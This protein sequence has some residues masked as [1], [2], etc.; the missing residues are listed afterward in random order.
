MAGSSC[1]PSAD[2]LAFRSNAGVVGVCTTSG[3]LKPF[4]FKG[5]TWHGAETT[6]MVPGGLD[7]HE[8]SFYFSFLLRNGFN[9][10]QL[11]FNH[12]SV[13]D[14]QPIPTD[15]ISHELNGALFAEYDVPNAKQT[16]V[17]YVEMLKQ[18][19]EAAQKQGMLVLLTAGRLTP[20]SWPGDGLW[21]NREIPEATL[22]ET[23]TTLAKAL[24]GSWNLLGVDLHHEP[25]KASWAQGLASHRWDEAAE[26][27]GNHILSECPRWLV[28]VEGI[29][30][31]APEDGGASKGYWWGENLVGALTKPITLTDPTRLVY[32]P[33]VEGPSSYLQS[34][35][36][37]R[38]FP[39]NLEDIWMDHF[40]RVKAKT[41]TPFVVGKL[42][43]KLDADPRDLMWLREA[44]AYFPTQS[45]GVFYASLGTTAEADGLL[46]DDWTTPATQ[47]LELLS[48][49]P[50]TDVGELRASSVPFPPPPVPPPHPP[51]PPPP[52]RGWPSPPPAP[53]PPPPKFPPGTIRHLTRPPPSPPP[54]SPPPP[55]PSPLPPRPPPSPLRPPPGL[56]P[57]LPLVERVAVASSAAVVAAGV[58]MS[59]GLIGVALGCLRI[60]SSGRS[61][62]KRRASSRGRT[63][64]E[65]RERGAS[66]RQQ[67]VLEARVTTLAEE[68][69][70]AFADIR[71]EEKSAAKHGVRG[72]MLQ[73]LRPWLGDKMLAKGII[74]YMHHE[75]R[76]EVATRATSLD[77]VIDADAI[78]I[79][80]PV[81]VALPSAADKPRQGGRAVGDIDVNE[82]ASLIEWNDEGRNGGRHANGLD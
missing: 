73:A 48:K 54:P 40:L 17:A 10:I 4:R 50:Y 59:I 25:H 33:H 68:G 81:E 38:L 65:R 42:G 69:K 79:V 67:V 27:L 51:P 14:D 18:V 24:C 75:E 36:R 5:V 20:T 72:A 64:P 7:T 61:R 74:V 2:G 39:K 8:L 15:G 70:P 76:V 16:G 29:N 21:F 37:D 58:V 56:P 32:A 19:V 52:P 9:A 80:V 13:R 53:H 12:K 31:G 6:A 47:T 23:W 30:H 22:L 63:A 62:P 46:K 43:A 66:R 35:F 28:F 45:V 77:E 82:G 78:E 71:M 44:V 34:Y 55:P 57:S 60:R 1:T 11:P 26:R 49:L 3:E 41:G